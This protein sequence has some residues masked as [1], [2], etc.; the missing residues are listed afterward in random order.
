MSAQYEV[1][2]V[3][4]VQIGM[5]QTMRVESITTVEPDMLA[6]NGLLEN[7]S[8]AT[9]LMQVEN[10]QIAMMTQKRFDPGQKAMTAFGFKNEEP[11]DWT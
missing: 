10:F 2:V 4:P 5:C 6:F 7:H 3:F 1:I 8:P 9:V 11:T